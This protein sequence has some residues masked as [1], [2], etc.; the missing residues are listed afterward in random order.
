MLIDKRQ[1]I[2][3]TVL[4]TKLYLKLKKEEDIKR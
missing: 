4:M 2:L 3:K 1:I